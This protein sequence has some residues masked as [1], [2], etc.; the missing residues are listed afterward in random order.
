MLQ[1]LVIS[2]LVFIGIMPSRA[3][4]QDIAFT[5]DAAKLREPLALS[6]EGKEL[7][8]FKGGDA[9]WGV[10]RAAPKLKDVSRFISLSNNAAVI[11]VSVWLLNEYKNYD[12]LFNVDIPVT[13]E[14]MQQPSFVF[15]IV[16]D[17]YDLDAPGLR[18]FLDRLPDFGKKP[19]VFKVRIEGAERFGGVF[20][21]NGFV[22][23][24]ANGLGRHAEWLAEKNALVA[25]QRAE[26]E[27]PL[28]AARTAFV[29][30][31]IAPR[32]DPRLRQDIEKWWKGSGAG[33]SA[34]L[35]VVACS[36]DYDIV[37]NVYGIV[38]SKQSCVLLAHKR[39]S[40]GKCFVQWRKFGYESLG[41]G[42]FDNQVKNWSPDNLEFT[43]SGEKLDAGKTYELDCSGLA[44]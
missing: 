9:V 14:Q 2:V 31:Y 18:K 41:G 36:S 33:V 17:K 11:R 40:D 37:R 8:R 43:M 4:A 3:C 34:L 28:I 42:A 44:R 29:A 38:T 30:S 16:P 7:E 1:I 20:A 15:P 19:I 10:L 32:D 25:G 27:R 5:N 6:T 23:D 12:P 26:R 24:L 13:R 35:K 21:Q 22:L 39:N